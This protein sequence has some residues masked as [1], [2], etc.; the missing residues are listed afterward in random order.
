MFHSFGHRRGVRGVAH[1][2]IDPCGKARN[3][4]K[5]RAKLRGVDNFVKSQKA[6]IEAE[7][8]K[9]R[10]KVKALGGSVEDLC[11]LGGWAKG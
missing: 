2:S 11:R 4:P 6:Q 8:A 9:A 1:F 10:E 7:I 5:T 3:G